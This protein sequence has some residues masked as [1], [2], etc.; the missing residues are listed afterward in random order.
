ME[1]AVFGIAKNESQA[2]SITNQ[3]KTAGFSQNDIS[4]LL[5]DKTGTRD[6]AHEQHTKAPEGAATGA[7]SGAVLGGGL[8]LLLGIGALAIPGLG[9]FIAAGPIMAA[10]AGAVAGAAVGGVAGA[11]IGMGIPEYEAKRYEGKI[12]DG[13]ILMSVHTRDG[14]ERDRAKEIFTNAGADDISYTGEAAAAERAD[15]EDW[16]EGGQAGARR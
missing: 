16:P 14:A 3:L 2:V 15:S 10:L 5:P 6:F 9:P 1:K 11:L 12:K 13:N 8:G 4:V 7:G